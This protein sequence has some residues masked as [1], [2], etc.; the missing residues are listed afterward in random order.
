MAELTPEPAKIIVHPGDIVQ[1][2]DQVH[3]HRGALLQ[4]EIVQAW[5]IG[6]EMNAIVDGTYCAAYVRLKP[7][8]FAVVGVAVLMSPDRLAARR[9]SL[10]T[11]AAMARER[12][13]AAKEK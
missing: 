7:D 5:G 8:Q 13:A 4:V 3:A 10:A 2:T 11:D 1:I 12:E 6:A 9:A